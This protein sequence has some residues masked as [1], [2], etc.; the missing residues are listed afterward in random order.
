MRKMESLDMAKILITAVVNDLAA[1]EEGFRSHTDLFAEQGL[2]DAILYGLGEGN[3]IA[4][5][6]ET[7]DPEALT[8]S[9]ASP[10]TIEAMTADGVMTDSVKI[11]QLD[12]ELEIEFADDF[13]DEAAEEPEDVA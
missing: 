2:E 12:R 11:I 7:D 5:V 10:E 4:V 8:A 6:M 1:W 13:D 3:L 9:L